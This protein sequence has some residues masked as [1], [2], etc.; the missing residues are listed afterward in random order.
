MKKTVSVLLILVLLLGVLVSCGG[1]GDP[2]DGLNGKDAAK[3]LLANERLDSNLLKE[4]DGIFVSGAEA[5]KNLSLLADANMVRYG[6]G[7]EVEAS[8]E[9]R[10]AAAGATRAATPDERHTLSAGGVFER[11]GNAY[12]WSEL[13][14]YSN[15]YDYFLNLTTNI[16]TSAEIGARLIDDTKRNVRIIDK[17]VMI[18][19]SNSLLLHVEEDSETI[20]AKNGL[21]ME[22]CSR[23]KREDGAN[24]YRIYRTT[25]QGG[26]IRMEY[27]PGE[28]CEYSYILD[29]FEHNFLAENTKGFWE[30]VDAN[31][32]AG[33][34]PTAECMVFKDDICYKGYYDATSGE[35]G[36]LT[37]ISPDKKTD[38]LTFYE[39]ETMADVT[40]ALQAFNGVAY[41]EQV[42]DR[43][44]T[45][46]VDGVFPEDAVV[47]YDV[48]RNPVYDGHTVYYPASQA[49]TLVT[50]NGTVVNVGNTYL[51]GAVEVAVISG[52]HRG[53]EGYTETYV[54]AMQL[55]VLG[56]SHEERMD[57]LERFLA[58]VGLECRRDF[59]GV[60]TGIRR[61]REEFSLMVKHREWNES[62]IATPEG[63]AK[64]QENNYKKHA[65]FAAMLDAVKDVEVIDYSDTRAVELNIHFAPI[66]AEAAAAVNANGLS[67]TATGLSLTVEDTTLFV[68]GERYRVS[69]ALKGE[70]GLTPL[71]DDGTLTAT[72]H[73]EDVFTVSTTATVALDVLSEGRYTLVAYIATAGDE[74]RTTGYRAVTLTGVE[75]YRAAVGAATVTTERTGAGALLLTVAHRAEVEVAVTL[76]D[77]PTGGELREA[78]ETAAYEYGFVEEGVT[79]EMQSG[80]GWIAVA[81]GADALASG[82]YRLRYG[83]HNGDKTVE[84]YV[85]TTYTAG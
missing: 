33:R 64:G 23:H 40:L 26:S 61:A 84:G 30:V 75:P 37:V 41:V 10:Y 62:P 43:I 27:I 34:A 31:G 25:E 71:A 20:Y 47:R 24:V 81:E 16:K 56:E 77:A 51:D 63:I 54:A 80:D 58:L 4:S 11:Y 72:Y 18:D 68:E 55:R 5:F 29:T 78:L 85:F 6:D 2:L 50:G 36:S 59:G 66:T 17:W 1:K 48:P 21:Y 44:V 38:I 79:L 67:V 76:S 69:F 65:A 7:E 57:T 42:S 53:M 13:G 14:E 73:G 52:D 74:I 39:G 3:L 32:G 15:N 9:M 28:K 12:R 22:I 46:P 83:V 8:V 60:R 19:P 45:T 35:I 82:T 70:S 49:C